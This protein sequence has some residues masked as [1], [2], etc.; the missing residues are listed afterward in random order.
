VICFA[1]SGLAPTC[2]ASAI[3]IVID[4]NNNVRSN[5]LRPGV[6][7]TGTL[8]GNSFALVAPVNNQATGETGEIIFSGTV[9]GGRISG[10]ISG[11]TESPVGPG[12]YSGTFTAGKL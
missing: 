6:A 9:S 12:S 2:S 4:K 7:L 5:D 3:T 11:T 10:Q 1:Q 8:S